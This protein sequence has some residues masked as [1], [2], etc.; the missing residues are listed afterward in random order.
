MRA[1]F[2]QQIR[3]AVVVVNFLCLGFSMAHWVTAWFSAIRTVNSQSS[4]LILLGLT[5][6]G[7]FGAKAFLRLL[8][9]ISQKHRDWVIISTFIFAGGAVNVVLSPFSAPN[10][11]FVL[12]FMLWAVFFRFPELA[13]PP[14]HGLE[15]F[16][17][18]FCQILAL[19]LVL[20]VSQ[21]FALC[22]ALGAGVWGAC[23]FSGFTKKDR[24][25]H[26]PAKPGHGVVVF[27]QPVQPACELLSGRVKV[28]S[29][30]GCG[31][32]RG[33]DRR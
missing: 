7:A 2:K 12:P 5:T 32:I 8:D 17:T 21:S 25:R 30:C 15:S 9:K 6:A 10:L 13:G 24:G 4:I 11:F 22:L 27:C 18:I 33:D 31:F 20:K 1:D 23:F 14:G 26:D 3:R 28:F 16:V 29:L 19:A